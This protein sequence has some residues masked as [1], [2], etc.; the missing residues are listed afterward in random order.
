MQFDLEF[1]IL[2]MVYVIFL[3]SIF[4]SMNLEGVEGMTRKCFGESSGGIL[5]KTLLV[6]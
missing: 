6:A 2:Y 1:Q 3:K 5:E 4:S